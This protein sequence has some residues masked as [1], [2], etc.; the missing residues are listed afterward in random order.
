MTDMRGYLAQLR[1]SLPYIVHSGGRYLFRVRRFAQKSRLFFAAVCRR[2]GRAVRYAR[3]VV[4]S[5]AVSLLCL[6]ALLCVFYGK[7]ITQLNFFVFYDDGRM[8]VHETY[9]TSPLEAMK[10]AG[11]YIGG[12]DYLQG[13]LAPIRGSLAEIIIDRVYDVTVR[14]DGR[15]FSVS[16]A[17]ETVASVLARTGFESRVGDRIAPRPDTATYADMEITVLRSISAFDTVTESIDYDTITRENHNMNAG[18]SVVLQK[19]EPGSVISV[20]EVITVDNKVV[21][22]ELVSTSYV[23]PVSEIVEVGTRGTVKTFDGTVLAYSRRLECTATAY[24][25]E[26]WTKKTNALGNI[27]RVGTIATDPKVIPYRSMVY[28]VAAN[29]KWE[30]GVARVE[31]SGGFRGNHVDLYFDTYDECINFGK[32]KCVVYVLY[33]D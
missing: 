24:T 5:R 29:N 27:A 25:T 15:H 28:V 22:R 31:D 26:R 10:E 4:G 14:Y 19:G 12:L 2:G 30:Y 17:G 7:Y 8:I 3:S 23:E 33:G 20:Y 18:T 9:A 32:R 11:I 1:F 16:T 13:S 6:A 21:L